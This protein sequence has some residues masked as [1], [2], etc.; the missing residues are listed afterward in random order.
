MTDGRTSRQP[1]RVYWARR[2]VVLA[3]LALV[4][5]LV[6]A[7]LAWVRGALAGND[8]AVPPSP[9]TTPAPTT[10]AAPTGGYADCVPP[11]LAVGITADAADV[12]AG[13][14]ATFTVTITNSGAEQCVVDAGDLQREVVI[15]SGSDRVW[16]SKDCAPAESSART[17]L[18]APGMTDTTQLAWNRER[19]APGCP[20]GL[21]APGPGTYQATVS[22]AGTSGG[23]VVF[24]LG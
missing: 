6:W 10:R 7:G 9:T 17:L 18:L 11:A 4:V 5:A 2:L 13:V 12:P 3:V 22:L 24:R 1:E 19:S 15:V 16:S 21:A 8:D 14:A 23:P 20:G